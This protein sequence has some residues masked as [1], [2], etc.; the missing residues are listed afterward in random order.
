MNNENLSMD[1][2]T[3]RWMG[4]GKNYKTLLYVRVP[5]I[6]TRI[7]L[8]TALDDKSCLLCFHVYRVRLKVYFF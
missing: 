1:E 5:Q 4:A 2:V 7:Y 3:L 6:K 8:R